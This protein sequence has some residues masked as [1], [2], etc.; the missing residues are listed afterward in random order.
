MMAISSAASSSMLLDDGGH[1][2]EARDP[3]ARAP[4]PL[5]GHELEVTVGP[6]PHEHGLEDA[7]L[8]DRRGQVLEGLL[9]E[10]LARLVRVGDD[11]VD[12]RAA[13]L[14]DGAGLVGSQQVDERRRVLG[15][16]GREPLGGLASEVGSSQESITSRARPRYVS[17]APD[18]L[19][20]DGHGLAGQGRLPESDGLS[21]DRIEDVVIAQLPELGEHVARQVGAPVVEGRQDAEDAQPR[22]QALGA[23]LRD[24]RVRGP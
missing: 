16:L 23:D 5:A 7:V 13:D 19:A 14:G 12:G 15:P 1:L 2:G 8:A 3:G 18:L 4:A 20:Y 11:A 17:A 21:H 24:D 22:V 10:V 6:R 9:V